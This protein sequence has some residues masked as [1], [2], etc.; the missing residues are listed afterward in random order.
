MSA[1]VREIEVR[2]RP[3]SG[4]KPKLG[5]PES[6][7][8]VM[9]ERLQDLPCER[10][11]ALYLN[12]R[13][14]LLGVHLVSAGTLN[15]SLVH[16]RDVFAPAL[17]ANAAAVIV[18]HNHPSGDPLPSREDHEVTRRLKQAGELLGVGLLDHVVIGGDRYQSFAR[19]GWLA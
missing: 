17:K 3:A 13:H 9:A 15:Q 14:R 1:T 8:A 12:T 5:S 7:F 6:V 16:P 2:Y 10:F 19:E 4:R 18:V 11:Y